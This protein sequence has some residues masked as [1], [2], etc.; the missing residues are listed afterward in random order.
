MPPAHDL[1]LS[2]THRDGPLADRLL[3]ALENVGV[4]VWRDVREID[5]FESIS[6]AIA[7]NMPRAVAMLCLYSPTYITRP[8]CQ[9]EL[10]AGLAAT[11]G[12]AGPSRLLVVN[13]VSTNEHILPASLRDKLY[14]TPPEASDGA[15][16]TKLASA[17]R[18]HLARLDGAIGGDP[19]RRPR[20]LPVSRPGAAPFVGRFRQLL[21]I[22][23][24]LHRVDF[25]ATTGEVAT[26]IA[27]ID[28]FVGTGKSRL[29]EQ[30]A[31]RFGSAYPLGVF[32]LDA[33]HESA[34]QIQPETRLKH[35]LRVLLSSLAI[36]VPG[37]A[38]TATLRQMLC[39]ALEGH[40]GDY[41]WIV[42]GLPAPLGEPAAREWMAPGPRGRTLM[43]TDRVGDWTTSTVTPGRF[44][45]EEA[46]H[47]F[48]L[49]R[50][51]TEADAAAALQLAEL[52]DHHPRGI[53][54]AASVLRRD[55]ALAIDELVR[56]IAD[57]DGDAAELADQVGGSA[58]ADLRATEA[59]LRRSIAE[60]PQPTRD[61]LR[62]ASVAAQATLPRE[63]VD[64]V[65]GETG[66]GLRG[67]ARRIALRDA[68]DRALFEQDSVGGLRVPGMVARLVR[69][70]EGDGRRVTQIRARAVTVVARRLA[71]GVLPG[72]TDETLAL[73]PHA[74]RLV[75]DAPS[76]SELALALADHDLER[77]FFAEAASVLQRLRDATPVD[78]VATPDP[79]A[80]ARRL[81]IALR[82]LGR[83]AEATE[84][85][86]I[87]IADASAARE[88]RSLAAA[89]A[90]KA[91]NVYL[92]GRVAEALPVLEEVH[93]WFISNAPDDVGR[94]SAAEYLANALAS[95]S[96]APEAVALLRTV[97][98]LRRETW[99][100][101]HPDVLAATANLAVTL[102]ALDPVEAFQL[103]RPAATRAQEIL[104]PRH[105]TALALEA[106]LAAAEM[107]K[108]DRRSAIKRQKHVLG[109]LQ[110]TLGNDHLSTM[111]ARANLGRFLLRDGT[112]QELIS[113][114]ALLNDVY[115]SAPGALDDRHGERIAAAIG[116]A[117]VCRALWAQQDFR[118]GLD[119]A[120][121]LTTWARDAA[122]GAYGEGHGI[123]EAAHEAHAV[124]KRLYSRPL[125]D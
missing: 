34:G 5:D 11:H 62:L 20:W 10:I 47:L 14:R 96:R 117:Q 112:K 67:G 66:G 55:R 101:D 63:L 35:E 119:Q 50:E 13:T 42:D 120:M 22:D 93:D 70:L 49:V 83:F 64:D 17:I 72:R 6:D 46:M 86:E 3:K 19:R 106:N 61:L 69:D 1:F 59:V 75:D 57:A 107:A 7:T 87:L 39:L 98:S 116:L 108:G 43:T 111:R 36:P 29:A 4:S 121:A 95:T 85:Q 73:V 9:W 123:T 114:Y 56:V 68:T 122:D 81:G 80:L 97:L 18:E 84:V 91:V 60:L 45:P 77:G 79:I 105:P 41:L 33:R 21:E 37:H 99:G 48:G 109:L 89:R 118:D 12:L 28:G 44:S 90:E 110:A 53:V 40:G 124:T 54:A 102:V 78:G 94:L 23:E 115:R 100:D 92:A 74:R 125:H 24:H 31:Q 103:L 104:G 51:L 71:N 27:I 2:Y 65:L 30:Y 26:P 113:A 32:W 76:S 52:L 58:A 15:G 82:E 38:D 16:W 25:A 88:M 8:A